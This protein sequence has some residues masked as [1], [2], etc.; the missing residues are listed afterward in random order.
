MFNTV[1]DSP[2][3]TLTASSNGMG[4]A[5]SQ[6]SGGDCGDCQNGDATRHTPSNGY[7][8]GTNFGNNL[9]KPT[10]MIDDVD[11]FGP[12][13]PQDQHRLTVGAPGGGGSLISGPT[14]ANQLRQPGGLQYDSL[15]HPIGGKNRMSNQCFDSTEPHIP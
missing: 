2:Y 14:D 7:T 6:F 9:N 10:S 13:R 11:V 8:H 3:E 1:H 12:V 15:G 5:Q 4:Q